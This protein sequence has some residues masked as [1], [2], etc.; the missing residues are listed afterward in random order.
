MMRH[1]WY[2][3]GFGITLAAAD[4]VTAATTAA[5]A[6]T[7]HP[8]VVVAVA[9]TDP[10]SSN[11][12]VNAMPTVVADIATDV[13]HNVRA[14][15]CLAPTVNDATHKVAPHTHSAD[16][17]TV[18]HE[19]IAA[20]DATTAV[21]NDT[22]GNTD[23]VTVVATTVQ[24]SW[25]CYDQIVNAI[26]AVWFWAIAAAYGLTI[27]GNDDKPGSE[28]ATKQIFV[29]T[30]TGKTI[31][32]DADN[33]DTIAVVK[34]K[35][36]IKA[37]NP[38]SSMR[39]IIAGKQLE[40]CRTIADYNIQKETTLHVTS[41]LAGGKDLYKLLGI[42]RQASSA[43]IQRA[44]K[45]LALRWHPDRAE[46]NG[47]TPAL[48]HA[49]TIELVEAR[50]TLLSPSRRHAHDDELRRAE[51]E[52]RE[53][54]ESLVHAMMHEMESYLLRTRAANEARGVSSS[55]SSC[56]PTQ[57]DFTYRPSP[58]PPQPKPKPAGSPPPQPQPDMSCTRSMPTQPD[59]TFRPSP[60]QQPVQPPGAQPD[61]P[62]PPKAMPKRQLPKP[63]PPRPARPSPPSST[64]SSPSM[65]SVRSPGGTLIEETA[66]WHEMTRGAAECSDSEGA[67]GDN[68]QGAA[69]VPDQW[70]FAESLA[71]KSKQPTPR[72]VWAQ[73]AP[74]P[75]ATVVS[76]DIGATLEQ[77]PASQG[78]TLRPTAKP[79]RPEA[80]RW[81]HQPRLPRRACPFRQL[82]PPRA[83]PLCPV[84]SAVPSSAPKRH[85]P[86]PSQRPPKRL[87]RR[88]G[89]SLV[90]NWSGTDVDS[91]DDESV[92]THWS[93]DE[94]VRSESESETGVSK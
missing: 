76:C 40:D 45:R 62:N 31:T 83:R 51:S 37:G 18:A 39:L 16:P 54:R 15:T 44:F 7:A 52:I 29:K 82:S 58:K 94:G 20:T 48:A 28:R 30:L 36:Q 55:S 5:A 56:A 46:Q 74:R 24:R 33:S 42:S 65:C 67:D 23:A 92:A 27:C 84:P 26:A 78:P 47:Y 77:E 4:I 19:P 50:E 81:K 60:Q 3:C 9:I 2:F 17:A 68:P 53:Q 41:S 11:D 59:F 73:P 90:N 32:I 80:T 6:V 38:T 10:R 79:F 25:I 1:Y 85:M 93:E 34:T 91:D 70:A 66:E 69:D 72:G 63:P 8:Q 43:D 57:P 21:A 12:A 71:P 49:M 75:K 64:P 14:H 88:A 86:K 61:R 13:G 35:I 22:W 87:Q 89:S